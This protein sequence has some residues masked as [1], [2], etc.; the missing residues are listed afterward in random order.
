M[1]AVNGELVQHDGVLRRHGRGHDL[2]RL[3]SHEH[4]GEGSV[5]RRTFAFILLLCSL[6]LQAAE[7]ARAPLPL[8]APVQDKNFYLLSLIE[9]TSDI[10]RVLA[11]D[12]ELTAIRRDKADALRTDWQKLRFSDAEI[13]IASAALLRLYK[14][15]GELRRSGA[16]VRYVDVTAAWADAARAINNILDVYGSGKAPR[17]PAIDSVSYDVKSEAY[18]KLLHTITASLAEEEM[19]LFFQPSLRFAL[20]LLD[21]NQRDE[22][23][24][25]E[26]LE[27][28]VNAAVVHRIASIDWKK[29]PYSVIVVPG[30]GPEKPGLALAPEGKLRLEL[31]A[32]RYRQGKAPLIMVSG[33][34]VHPNQTP[35]CEAIE[36]Q[37]SLVADFGVPADA[38]ILEPQARHTTT[39]LRNA[40]R[41]IYRYGIPFERTVLITTDSYQRSYIESDAFTKRCADELHYQPGKI[42]RRPSEFDLEFTPAI[43]SLQIDPMDPL[44]P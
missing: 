14:A 9:R 20:H 33:G 4:H 30:Y 15:D 35:Y 12:P 8:R 24:R 17:Y 38:I 5:I 39:N 23:G 27:R 26:P 18:T 22:A 3:E 11:N 44:D 28:G 43:D 21:V 10:A 34:Y 42:G 2:V 40:T 36:M 16:Y 7:P 25:L 19:P 31:A 41:L 32:R 6:I 29:Y 1:Y 37:K 13:A